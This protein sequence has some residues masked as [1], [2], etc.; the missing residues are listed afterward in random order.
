M[1]GQSLPSFN[2]TSFSSTLVPRSEGWGLRADGIRRVGGGR[3]GRRERQQLQP[4]QLPGT[5]CR[6][7]L[8]RKEPKDNVRDGE[9][10]GVLPARIESSYELA[11]AKMAP[12]KLDLLSGE[13]VPSIPSRRCPLGG[14]QQR[15]HT[16]R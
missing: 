5:A 2:S 9:R 11:S 3:A 6:K 1:V 13:L 4:L 7:F 15:A 12:L 14:P 8:V 10:W 16:H